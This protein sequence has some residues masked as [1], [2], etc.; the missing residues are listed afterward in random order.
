MAIRLVALDIDGTLAG[1]AETI[2]PHI[3]MKLRSMEGKGIRFLL[4]SGKP[5]AY[6]AGLAR[7]LGL[8]NPLTAGETGGVIFDPLTLWE[9]RLSVIPENVLIEMKA[10]ILRGFMDVW[11]QQNQIMLTVFPKDLSRIEEIYNLL[12]QLNIRARYDF[13][14][15]KHE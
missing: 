8:K 9:K 14:I 2:P 5:T 13:R 3:G 11:F 12:Q 15:F 10:E 4:I 6:L 1:T 7:G